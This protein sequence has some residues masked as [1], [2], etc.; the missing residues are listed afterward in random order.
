MAKHGIIDSRKTSIVSSPDSGYLRLKATENNT[1][2]IIRDDGTRTDISAPW[3]LPVESKVI[4]DPTTLTP[5]IW[6]RW[7]VGIG[8]TGDWN[9]HD[10]EIAQ[11]NGTSYDFFIPEVGW[12]VYVK[13]V[14]GLS[15]FDG[16]NWN[17]LSGASSGIEEFS[18]TLTSTDIS[19]GF[20]DIGQTI[21]S[22]VDFRIR[23]AGTQH[24]SLDYEIGT[25]N[26]RVS[27]TGLILDGQLRIGHDIVILYK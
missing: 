7:I 22:L 23:G 18:T 5:S 25:P 6:Q 2:E 27:W 13:D 15:T 11:W 4:V 19:N 20:V 17:D 24:E 12:A 26:S 9:S 14:T 1:F 8:S 10:D 3:S 16:S 21:N